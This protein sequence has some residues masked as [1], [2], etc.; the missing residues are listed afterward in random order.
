MSLWTLPYIICIATLQHIYALTLKG[1]S[2]T[3]KHAPC[4]YAHYCQKHFWFK[5][6][7]CNRN[8]L[9]GDKLHFSISFLTCLGNK[10]SVKPWTHSHTCA[11]ATSIFLLPMEQ[12]ARWFPEGKMFQR[13]TV[14]LLIYFN[15]DLLVL[16]GGKSWF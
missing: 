7:F 6:C 9:Q 5:F 16:T 2:N 3:Q 13:M 14:L 10:Y 15:I 12:I 1:N 11:C 8:Y 4:K